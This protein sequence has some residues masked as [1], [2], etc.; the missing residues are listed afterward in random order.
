MKKAMP[1]K[2]G[3]D[4]LPHRITVSLV[5]RIPRFLENFRNS[6]MMSMENTRHPRENRIYRRMAKWVSDICR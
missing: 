2:A 3:F 4:W 5:L 6:P 1:P